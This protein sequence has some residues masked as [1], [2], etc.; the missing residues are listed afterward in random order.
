MWRWI[1]EWV[2]LQRRPERQR[3][4]RSAASCPWPVPPFGVGMGLETDVKQAFGHALTDHFEQPL[5]TAWNGVA[6]GV[7]DVKA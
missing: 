2:S 7:D 4:P 1:R 5:Q 6:K 3:E